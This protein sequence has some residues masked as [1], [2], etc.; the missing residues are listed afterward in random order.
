MNLP[1]ASHEAASSSHDQHADYIARRVVDTLLREDVRQCVS[2]GTIVDHTALPVEISAASDPG[3]QWLQIMHFGPDQLWIPVTPCAYMQTWRSSPL[4]LVRYSQGR[5][6]W[7]VTVEQI[8]GCFR[9]G[10]ADAQG[11]LDFEAEC[12]AA[13]EHR[14]T[15]ETERQRW[16]GEWREHMAQAYGADLPSWDSRLQHYDRL[17]A[18][19]DHP[20]YPTA[21]AKLGFGIRD[22]TQYA[23]EFQP[24]FKLNWLAVPRALYHQQGSQLPP[25][26]P[27]FVEV[28]LD[29]HLAQTHHLV[30]VHP[31]VW[32]SELETFLSNSNLDGQCLRAP[33]TALL[34]E[35]TLSV[36]TLA[37]CAAPAWH[38]KVP[39]TIRTLGG[40]NIRT[41]KPSTISDGHLIQ[42][43]LGHI[44]AG[45]AMLD[46]RVLLSVED[47]GAHVAWQNFLGFILRR[48]PQ[49]VLQQATMMP[50]AAL[51][52][53]TPA[54]Y[55]VMEE[56]A[57]RFYGGDMQRF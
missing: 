14:T 15:C 7:L 19:Q 27:G 50:V 33:L 54:G 57:Q 23:P 47:T 36:R 20:Y 10:L 34:V 25:G 44:V 22:L 29:A 38:I 49:Q 40:R 1:V 3:Q 37:L 9:Q 13:I 39:L 2:R 51:A 11:Y 24:R 43:L 26:W 42:T 30:P 46:G 8:L 52:A 45:E 35:P 21:R 56:A 12:Q 48:Y 16:F 6:E 18:F 31:F 4:P 17:A 5:G 32:E 53:K 41:I 28:G 55:T